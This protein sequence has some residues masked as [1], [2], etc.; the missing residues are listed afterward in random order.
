MKSRSSFVAICLLITFTAAQP[1]S[2]FFEDL[3][4]PRPNAKGKTKLSWCLNP[5]CAVPPQPNTACPAQVIEFATVM[6][7]R[8]M[9]HADSTYSSRSPSDTAATA[10]TGSRRTTK[11]L[12]RIA[13]SFAA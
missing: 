11:S 9:L 8:S 6:P 12:L 3:C 7:G 10:R 4:L 2:A 1:A 13:L 5:I